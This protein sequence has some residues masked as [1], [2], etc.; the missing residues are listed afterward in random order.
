MRVI[1]LF[2]LGRFRSISVKPS[3]E[4]NDSFA[5]PLKISIRP[6]SRVEIQFQIF[7]INDFAILRHR[8]E[9]RDFPPQFRSFEP[10]R[11]PSFIYPLKAAKA[12]APTQRRDLSC[13]QRCDYAL[14][15]I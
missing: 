12:E 6:C 13:S 15:T 10:E 1:S 4:S 7:L 3:I 11:G 5:F 9:I 14:L 8:K 2:A